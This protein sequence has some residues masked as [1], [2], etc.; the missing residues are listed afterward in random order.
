MFQKIYNRFFQK[1]VV[2]RLALA[3]VIALCTVIILQT[4]IENLKSELQQT[5][6]F[7]QVK[8]VSEIS[9][10]LNAPQS[11]DGPETI[12]GVDNRTPSSDPAVAALTFVNPAGNPIG[13][14]TA[15]LTSNGALLTAGHCVDSDPD[16]GGPLLPDGILDIDGNDLIEFNVPAS[17]AT[18]GLQLA[19]PNDQ[20][21][22]D[23]NSIEWNYDGEGQ[24]LGDD[25]AIFSVFPN[26]NTG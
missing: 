23:L 4:N 1:W 8:T 18:G 25:W 15:W 19:E 5:K 21:T 20:Y 2:T 14:C 12:C 16:R 9:G 3:I 13:R 22:I 11:P 17:T 6:S 10:E 26:A 24:G 7:L